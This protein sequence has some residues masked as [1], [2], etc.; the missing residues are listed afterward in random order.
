MSATP[1]L[2]PAREATQ[3][4]PAP[5]D[6]APPRGAPPAAQPLS[7][8]AAPPAA[9]ANAVPCPL[10]EYDL[11]GLAEPRCPECG[12]HFTWEELSDPSR[13]FH[14]YLFEHHPERNR[15]SFWN[16]LLAG[17]LPI[18]FWSTLFPTQPSR[19]Q[20]I[21]AY[22]VLCSVP[23]LV[24]TA[25]HLW[26]TGTAAVSQ[27]RMWRAPA[28]PWPLVVR[29]THVRDTD[30]GGYGF[31]AL[32]S[33]AW[34]WLTMASL[35]VFQVSLR[36]AKLRGWHVL[37]CA[38]YA[39]DLTLWCGLLLGLQVGIAISIGS[40]PPRE[41]GWLAPLLAAVVLSLL[42]YRLWTAYRLYLRF[43][44]ALATVL[45]SQAMVLLV[46]WKLWLM[47]RGY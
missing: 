2:E 10:C 46:Y 1:E 19:P 36:R 16:T 25:V 14:P 21:V 4:P 13:R 27:L 34:P 7:Y 44:H 11:R 6:A 30:A 5:G 35:L 29:M 41:F 37:R 32:A 45:A 39:G 12:Y 31:L 28:P 22:W 17:L 26:V 23:L 38:L 8:H 15:W 43:D 47:A 24:V 20:R 40:W 3:T 42:V 18:R 9:A 33:L